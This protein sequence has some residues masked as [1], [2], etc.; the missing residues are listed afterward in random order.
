MAAALAATA[1]TA[2]TLV[3]SPPSPSAD[4]H[5]VFVSG[6]AAKLKDFERVF[7]GYVDYRLYDMD[8]QEIQSDAAGVAQHKCA[9]ALSLLKDWGEST[10]VAIE[11]TCKSVSMTQIY[12]YNMVLFKFQL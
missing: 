5:L 1:A 10:L 8:L 6:N 7:R 12:S 4:P 9:K 3:T 11:D 2:T